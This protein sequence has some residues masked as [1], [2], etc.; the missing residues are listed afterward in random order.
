MK[1]G[2]GLIKFVPLKYRKRME[3]GFSFKDFLIISIGELNFNKNNRIVIQAISKLHYKD[4]HYILCG[5]G[6]EQPY[7][8]SLA[9]EL[10]VKEQT[11]FLGYCKNI[12]DILQMSDVFILPSFREG[13]SR[14]LTEAMASG[15]PIIASK[16]RGNIDLVVEGE[17]G[18]LCS[19]DCSEEFVDVIRTLKADKQKRIDIGKF[20]RKE[21]LKY[22]S[23]N[24]VLKMKEIYEQVQ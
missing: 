7:L 4:V 3:L 14:S 23:E 2:G 22:S 24:V 17:G 20:N 21:S 18:A 12:F 19:P 1:S 8:E 11:H 6:K 10:G 15:L 9:N 5:T 13:L 16:I